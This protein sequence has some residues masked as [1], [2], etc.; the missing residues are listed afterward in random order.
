[1]KIFKRIHARLAGLVFFKTQTANTMKALSRLPIMCFLFFGLYLNTY[2]QTDVNGGDVSGLWTKANAPYRIYD[3]ITIPND[4]T[5]TIEA[6]VT[7]EFQGYHSI[8]VQGNLRAI[9]VVTDSIVFT[10][11]DTTGFS[12]PNIP[13]GGWNGVR[14]IDTNQEN[15]SSIFEYCRFKYGKAVA[16]VW[17]LNAGGAMC[18]I[19]FDKVRVSHCLF[20]NNSAGGL[21]VPSGGAIHLAWS[22]IQLNDNLFTE[23]QAISGGAIQMHESDPIFI[24]NTI[25]HNIARE[26]GGVS[27]GSLSNP[28]FNGD[29]LMSNQATQFGGGLMCWDKAVIHFENVFV[30]GNTAP[31]GGGV[32]LA[33]IKAS[34]SNCVIHE[35]VAENLGGGIASDFSNVS[36]TNSEVTNNSANMSGGI[37]A[38]YD[39]LEIDL[40]D[41]SYNAADYGGGIHSDFSYLKLQNSSFSENTAINGGGVHIWNCDLTIVACDFNNNRVQ[42]E[43]GAIECYYSDTLVYGRPYQID[44]LQSQFTENDAVFR[45]GAVKIEQIDSD[46]SFADITLD[47]NIFSKNHAERVAGILVKGK[48]KDFLVTNSRFTNN[49]TDLWNGGAS[50]AQG[51]TGQII[52]CTFTDNVATMGNPGASGVS[53]GSFVHYINCTFAN[54][55]AGSVGGLST[56]RDGKASITNCIFWNNTP[57]QISVRGIREGAFSELYVN[58]CNIQYGTDSIEVDTLALLHWGLGNIDS[59]P[60]FYHPDNQDYHLL[61]ESPCIDAGVD[62]IEVNGQWQVAPEVDMEGNQ[63]PQEG[64]TL[65]DI[66]AYENQEVLAFLS[67]FESDKFFVKTYP[68][69]FKQYIYFELKL[70]RT[71]QVSIIIYDLMGHAVASVI[72][73]LLT[74][75]KHQFT[76]NA[77]ARKEGLYIC[78]ISLEDEIFSQKIFLT[79]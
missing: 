62:S 75:G 70:G 64:S 22:D 50:F 17:H 63:R 48:F 45:S 18:I 41:I 31:W 39:T 26:G 35:N 52:N 77:T 58:H 51:C 60:L 8:Q 29:T 1:M 44:I 37:H 78:R 68:N 42:N 55:S 59:D 47:K 72:N 46:T 13:S 79:P 14:I 21:E 54:N 66:G 43:S 11:Q 15:D 25:S 5:L 71:T 3:T 30:Q 32:G 23:N 38:W 2:A 16:D 20:I 9:G 12:N 74:E 69:P 57:R 53:N 10:I 73:K 7:I 34:F 19:H 61:D 36:I 6:G 76:W 27:I 4:S 33:G 56:H 67:Q 49:L 28:T 24:N 40:S 65:L